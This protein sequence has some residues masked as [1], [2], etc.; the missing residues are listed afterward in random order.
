[1]QGLSTLLTPQS[2]AHLTLGGGAGLSCLFDHPR[3]P[4][5][6]LLIDG[7]FNLGQRR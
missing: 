2:L 6:H 4:S 3:P 7:L 1:L 5:I